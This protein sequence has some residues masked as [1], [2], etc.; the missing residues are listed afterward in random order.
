MVRN[1]VVLP[2]ADHPVPPVVALSPREDLIL[3]IHPCASAEISHSVFVALLCE[4]LAWRLCHGNLTLRLIKVL[5]A[6]S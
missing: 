2:V 1:N 6:L 3:D 4:R 5:L